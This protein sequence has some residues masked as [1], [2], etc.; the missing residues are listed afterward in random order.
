MNPQILLAV[1]GEPG[2]VFPGSFFRWSNRQEPRPGLQLNHRHC[3]SCAD[4]S[5]DATHLLHASALK[6]ILYPAHIMFFKIILFLWTPTTFKVDLES[7]LTKLDVFLTYPLNSRNRNISTVIEG[8]IK[9]WSWFIRQENWENSPKGSSGD[10]WAHFLSP[11]PSHCHS[12]LMF[13]WAILA[14]DSA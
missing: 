11:R 12:L 13:V 1:S 6:C 2:M 14:P 10:N 3:V 7:Y 9:S 8:Y 4:Q 5:E